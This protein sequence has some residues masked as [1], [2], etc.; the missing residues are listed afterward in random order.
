MSDDIQT[1]LFE[2]LNSVHKFI[3]TGRTRRIRWLSKARPGSV[4]A[5][6]NSSGEHRVTPDVNGVYQISAHPQWR[7]RAEDLRQ[8][9]ARHSGAKS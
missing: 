3:E 6:L 9:I 4:E 5:G 7:P 2:S 1:G 8:L